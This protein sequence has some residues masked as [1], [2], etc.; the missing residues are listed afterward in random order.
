MPATISRLL[1]GCRR[2]TPATITAMADKL[3]CSLAPLCN[4]SGSLKCLTDYLNNAL[5]SA[6]DSV[7]PLVIKKRSLKKTAPWF[8]EET[9][10]LKQSCGILERKWRS[11]KLEVFH[12]A[13]HNS[14]LPYKGALTTVRNAY[15]SSII[16]LNRNNLKFLFD[17]VKSLT[18]KQT[19]SVG[20]SL[21]AGQFMD[22]FGN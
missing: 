22:F 14:L 9:H 7:A 15:F 11:T 21:L 5:S 1:F 12:L 17:T 13:W 18:Q 20:S 2:I 4:Y 3:P 19:Q 8:N 6:I 10:T 16:N